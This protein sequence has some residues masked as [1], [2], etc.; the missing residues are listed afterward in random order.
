MSRSIRRNPGTSW[1]VWGVGLAVIGGA[2]IVLSRRK[3]IVSGYDPSTKLSVGFDRD[4]SRVNVRFLTE[5][6]AR[7]AAV[8]QSAQLPGIQFQVSYDL[9]GGG[10]GFNT[11]PVATY[12]NGRQT[13]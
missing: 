6:G 11:R 10:E 12:T 3:Y 1:W 9:G 5:S 13:A 8:Q 2:A 4:P 7:T